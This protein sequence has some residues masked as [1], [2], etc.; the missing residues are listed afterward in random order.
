MPCG[1]LLILSDKPSMYPLLLTELK[2]THK[3][4]DRGRSF[5]EI[6]C[7]KARLTEKNRV[8][9]QWQAGEEESGLRLRWRWWQ[10]QA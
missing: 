10:G 1:C 7:S 3:E 6:Y 9:Q 5:I 4:R 8:K 2:K